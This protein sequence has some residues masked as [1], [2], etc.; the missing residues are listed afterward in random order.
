[1]LRSLS[2]SPRNG[3]P[4]G[5]ERRHPPPL[6]PPGTRYQEIAYRSTLRLLTLARRL[7]IWWRNISDYCWSASPRIGAEAVRWFDSGCYQDPEPRTPTLDE[8]V[9]WCENPA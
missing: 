7:G 3:I 5:R 4:V 1:M 9:E 8:F 6:P 2:R